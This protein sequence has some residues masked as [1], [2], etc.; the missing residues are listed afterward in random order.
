M[1]KVNNRAELAV[2]KG[3][4]AEAPAPV[5][6][7]DPGVQQMQQSLTMMAGQMQQAA[8]AMIE[9]AR[10]V[11]AAQAA[12]KKLEAIVHRDKDGKMARVEINVV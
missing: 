3:E 4:K 6:Q 8:A 2:L 1:L 5:A 11:Q 7:P 10:Q 12:P 9:T